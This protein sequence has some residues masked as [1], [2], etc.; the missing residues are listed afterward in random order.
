MPTGYHTV[1]PDPVRERHVQSVGH[2]ARPLHPTLKCYTPSF[3][4][5][6]HFDGYIEMS[7]DDTALFW[8]VNLNRRV[9]TYI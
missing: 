2:F 4:Y 3:P 9:R 5:Q 7:G 1:P 6:R 8:E